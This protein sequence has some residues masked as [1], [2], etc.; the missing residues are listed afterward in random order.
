[1]IT[2]FFTFVSSGLIF[3]MTAAIFM[4]VLT[5]YVFHI[6][7][8]VLQ[9]VIAFSMRWLTMLGSA[10]ALEKSEHFA[11]NI[12]SDMKQ[13]L[14]KKIITILREIFILIAILSLIYSGYHFAIMG[15]HKENPS[16]GLP[17]VYTFSSVLVGSLAMLYYFIKS[18]LR[19][20]KGI[21]NDT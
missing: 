14:F 16:S 19:Q 8:P 4:Q 3:V 12:F 2:N 15:L 11:I 1:M 9:F 17:E 20:R 5:R 10:V 6:S 13:T 7:I 18:Q 21:H